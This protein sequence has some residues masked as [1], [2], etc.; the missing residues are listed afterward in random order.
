MKF[1]E[2]KIDDSNFYYKTKITSIDN[3]QL[4]K[5]LKLN[6]NLNKNTSSQ[7]IGPGIQSYV[8][9]KTQEII[10]LNQIIYDR[11]FDFLGY[12]KNNLGPYFTYEWVYISDKNNK[13]TRF[14]NHNF[15]NFINAPMDWTFTYYVQMPDNLLLEDGKLFFKTPNLE[16]SC[17]PEVGD[18]ILFSSKLLHKPE[19]N[20]S[21]S[22]ERIVYAGNFTYLNSKDQYKKNML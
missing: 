11:I 9:I 7:T 4:I 2:I 8:I 18:L 13:I 12:D 1:E 21:S 22:L 15:N 17:M 3:N 19:L 14:H 10:K 5:D 20:K 16:I 6:I